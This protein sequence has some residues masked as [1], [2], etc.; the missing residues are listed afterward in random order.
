VKGSPV[1]A[2]RCSPAGDDAAVI[3]QSRSDPER[4]AVLFDR[5]SDEIHRYVARRLGGEIA[6]DVVSDTFL[7]AFR[8]R[9]RYDLD[10]PDARPW[11]YGI[12]TNAI[13]EHRRAEQRHYRALARADVQVATEPFDERSAARITAE[14]LQPRL[15]RAWTRLSAA[16]RDLLLLVAWADLT[17][18]EAW[19]ALGIPEGT[20]KSRLHRVRHKV[21][22][23][24]G[25]IDPTLVQEES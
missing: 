20:V 17:Y 6:Q 9:D 11:L 8:K 13:R 16:E 21:R 24:F 3:E 18:Q 2:E 14:Q 15:A 5:H 19:R 23:A 22:K 7:T 25:G 1:V 10:H 4:F 12:A